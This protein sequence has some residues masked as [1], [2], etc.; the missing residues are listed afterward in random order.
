MT[1]LWCLPSSQA[2]CRRQVTQINVNLHIRRHITAYLPTHIF[3]L[4]TVPT[5]LLDSC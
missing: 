1:L 4:S 3:S 5:V 2:I